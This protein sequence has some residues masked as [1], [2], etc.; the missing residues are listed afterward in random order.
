MKTA[1][2]KA[3]EWGVSSS[4]VAAYC[5]SGIIPPA[6]KVGKRKRW[7]IPD[8][9]CKPPLSRRQLCFLLDTVDQIH[10]G[11]NYSDLNMGHKDDVLEAGYRYLI[12]AGFLTYKRKNGR[13]RDLANAFV[14]ARGA[15]LL[16]RE[17]S[18]SKDGVRFTAH[19]KAGASLGIAKVELGYEVS[20]G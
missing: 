16:E 15:S 9:W 3:V 12:A 2:E 7:E 4:T 17:N 14:T 18:N 1:K 10:L 5:A 8:D 11:T 13:T 20:N 6:E 19:V